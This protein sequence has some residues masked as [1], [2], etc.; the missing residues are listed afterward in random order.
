MTNRKPLDDYDRNVVSA[1]FERGLP[2]AMEALSGQRGK[3]RNCGQFFDPPTSQ[4][5]TCAEPLDFPY[6]KAKEK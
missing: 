4:C 6:V 2:H 1:A 5:P 3:C